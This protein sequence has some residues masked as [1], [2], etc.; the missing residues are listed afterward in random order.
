[1]LSQMGEEM[2]L[3]DVLA[4]SEE[5]ESIKSSDSGARSRMSVQK[6]LRR[7]GSSI[8]HKGSSVRHGS[9][10]T[11]QYGSTR[12]DKTEKIDN[13]SLTKLQ[14]VEDAAR[15][16]M[17]GSVEGCDN[18]IGDLDHMPSRESQRH[19]T[20]TE[21]DATYDG[22]TGRETVDTYTTNVSGRHSRGTHKTLSTTGRK[23]QR[24]RGVADALFSP[25]LEDQSTFSKATTVSFTSGDDTFSRKDIGQE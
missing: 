8:K 9:T 24:K 4:V 13:T 17:A 14:D 15:A 25:V 7:Q 1:M 20:L 23:S 19:R 5:E 10:R 22:T 21:G 12:T 3:D 18:T 6:G 2:G 11:D 16:I